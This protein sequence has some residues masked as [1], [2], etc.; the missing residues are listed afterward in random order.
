MKLSDSDKRKLDGGEG[1]AVQH[2]M[3]HLA[4]FGE[5]FEADEMIDLHTCHLLSDYRTM[6][7]GGLEFYEQL[8]A[9]GGTMRVPT[10]CDPMSWI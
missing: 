8:V 2:A 10:T 4:K 6:G 1:P 5:A 7:D 9:W 3:E